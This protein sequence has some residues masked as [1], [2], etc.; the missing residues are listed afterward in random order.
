[1]AD[2]TGYYEVYKS[3]VYWRWRFKAW[4]HEI[5]A[6]GEDYYNKSDCLAAVNL[7]KGSWNAPV[8]DA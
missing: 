2:T 3:G 1:M 8:Y 4:N 5:I 6:S 7:M